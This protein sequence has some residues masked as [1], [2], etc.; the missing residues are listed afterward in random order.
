MDL[1]ADLDGIVPGTAQ[2]PGQHV[3]VERLELVGV[4]VIVDAYRWRAPA[5]D[6]DRAAG[7]ARAAARL[8]ATLGYGALRIAWRLV[9]RLVRFARIA[10]VVTDAVGHLLLPRSGRNAAMVARQRQSGVNDSVKEVSK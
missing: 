8:Q 7:A 3:E 10:V 4:I 1:A 5:P 2:A 6:R 9:A